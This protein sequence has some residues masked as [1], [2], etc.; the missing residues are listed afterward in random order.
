MCPMTETSMRTC[1][2]SGDEFLC[3]GQNFR[4]ATTKGRVA[5][6][7]TM[8]GVEFRT[9]YASDSVVALKEHLRRE[10]VRSPS[11]V[12]DIAEHGLEIPLGIQGPA[13]AASSLDL[14]YRPAE[15]PIKSALA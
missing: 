2:T 13:E 5:G 12:F 11:F 1:S 8:N 10:R 6:A 7:R 15:P 4:V 9:H 14:L 3:I